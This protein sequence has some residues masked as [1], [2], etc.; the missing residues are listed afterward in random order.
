VKDAVGRTLAESGRLMADSTLDPQ[1]HSFT[2]RML[3]ESGHLLTR[4]E[5]WQRHTLATDSTIRPGRSIVIRYQFTIPTEEKGPLVITAKVNYRH[6][7]QAFTN[8]AFGEKHPLYPVIEMALRSRTLSI[9]SNAPQQSEA[10]DNADWMRWNNFGI[11]LLDQQQYAQAVEAFNEARKLHPD[12]SDIAVNLGLAYY[13]LEQ[14]S[15]AGESGVPGSIC[16]SGSE[17]NWNERS[18]RWH[19]GRRI[20][21]SR[22]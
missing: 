2:N 18:R 5:V 13:R 4:H 20:V 21:Q 15:Q 12:D 1:A 14:S 10:T 6:L 11:A 19:E 7:N 3:D 22:W 8:F 17:T 16:A 9:G